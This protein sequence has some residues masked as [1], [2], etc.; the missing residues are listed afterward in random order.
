MEESNCG[1]IIEPCP[2]NRGSMMEFTPWVPTGSRLK[3]LKN[4]GIEEELRRNRGGILRFVKFFN[5]SKKIYACY[6]FGNLPTSSLL[7]YI[8]FYQNRWS[9]FHVVT[10]KEEKNGTLL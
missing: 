3:K 10:K 2:R 5:F 4:C 1:G 8:D 6:I 7:V 9:R